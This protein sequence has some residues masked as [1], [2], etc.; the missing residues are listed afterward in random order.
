M[1]VP[2]GPQGPY[3][4][5]GQQPSPYGQSYDPAQAQ[6]YAP[7]Q[8]QAYGA[9]T[10]PYGA[11][12]TPNPYAQP[13]PQ[14]PTPYQAGGSDFST[15]QKP[16]RPWLIPVIAVAT[17]L[18][19]LG[20]GILTKGDPPIPA[21]T[22]VPPV[23]VTATTQPPP[24]KVTVTVTQRGGG[25]TTKP[26][27][28]SGGSFGDGIWQ[29]GTDIQPGDYISTVPSGSSCY[30]ALLRTR[31]EKDVLTSD[32]APSGKRVTVTVPDRDAFFLS[33]GCGTWTPN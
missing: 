30:I 27:T 23:T 15:G 18:A 28:Q 16:S 2:G 9:P 4:S 31:N 32:T 22:P 10:Q 20:I 11:P 24:V 8:G 14:Q 6:G 17:F 25:T 19:G 13:A 21:P 1:S 26:T 33:R 29:I 5:G 7:A 12:A 3:Y